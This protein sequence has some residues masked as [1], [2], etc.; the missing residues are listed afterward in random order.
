MSLATGHFDVVDGAV[1][2]AAVINPSGKQTQSCSN[3][4]DLQ[5]YKAAAAAQT[6]STESKST[7]AKKKVDLSSAAAA[8]N[9]SALVGGKTLLTKGRRKGNKQKRVLTVQ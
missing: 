8:V 4:D 6:T 5:T 2:A 7:V 3:S 9:L 1:G